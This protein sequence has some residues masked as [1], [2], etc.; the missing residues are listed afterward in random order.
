MRFALHAERGFRR[1]QHRELL[2][3]RCDPLVQF[4]AD[5]LE[6]IRFHAIVVLLPEMLGQLVFELVEA[7]LCRLDPVGD[8]HD[9]S[10]SV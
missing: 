4:V 8:V 6:D 10:R 2:L 1:L 9:R 3:R 5:A 7:G